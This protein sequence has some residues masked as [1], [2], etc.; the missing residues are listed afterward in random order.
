M[1]QAMATL[2]FP[3]EFSAP[4]ESPAAAAAPFTDAPASEFAFPADFPAI[5]APIPGG[6]K[7]CRVSAQSSGGF[8][9]SDPLE[10]LFDV[11]STPIESNCMRIVRPMIRECLFW[12]R[13]EIICFFLVSSLLV[14]RSHDHGEAL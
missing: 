3:P 1:P 6:K 4:P 2:S 11:K 14:P 10:A 7:D 9:F 8:T 5:A 12:E 13:D